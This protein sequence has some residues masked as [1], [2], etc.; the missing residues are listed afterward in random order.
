MSEKHAYLK[1]EFY[2]QSRD[3]C[4]STQRSDLPAEKVFA[5]DSK[6]NQERRCGNSLPREKGFSLLASAKRISF[7]NSPENLIEPPKQISF[8][9]N[10]SSM[11]L[12][13]KNFHKI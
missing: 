6:Q 4:E 2:Q 3:L 12:D 10:P 13:Q 11:N 1:A 9:D 5:S 8:G 7:S